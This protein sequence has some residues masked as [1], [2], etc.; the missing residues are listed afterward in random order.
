MVLDAFPFDVGTPDGQLWRE[1]R[2]AEHGGRV[3]VFVSVDG[4]PTR[5]AD[6]KLLEEVNPARQITRLV[7]DDGAWTIDRSP[8]CGCRNVLK[9]TTKHMLMDQID[10]TAVDKTT[11]GQ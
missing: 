8:G 1:A 11:V 10:P 6:A 5:V 3:Y 9:R 7:T 2:I 4:K